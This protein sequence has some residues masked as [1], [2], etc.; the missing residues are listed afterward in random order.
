MCTQLFSP[1]TTGRTHTSVLFI[2]SC[3]LHSQHQAG[4]YMPTPV[5]AA[6]SPGKRLPLAWES[7]LLPS[8]PQTLLPFFFIG[9]ILYQRNPK[10]S[11]FLISTYWRGESTQRRVRT[12]SRGSLLFPAGQPESP[13]AF[14]IFLPFSP[15]FFPQ[16]PHPYK[17]LM[18]TLDL[19]G[20]LCACHRASTHCTNAFIHAIQNITGHQIWFPNKQLKL[21]ILQKLL[22]NNLKI[23]YLSSSIKII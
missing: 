18:H 19:V 2:S 23:L 10:L 22:K 14:F 1:H 11:F 7:A 21:C 3:H 16:S 17:E 15:D 8:N 12:L 5:A 4:F 9:S 20:Q 13:L 6:G